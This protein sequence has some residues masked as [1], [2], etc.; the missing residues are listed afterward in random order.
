[1]SNFLVRLKPDRQKSKRSTG[2]FQLYQWGQ[3]T[4]ENPMLKE[5]Y[6]NRTGGGPCTPGVG[7]LF[8]DC[9]IWKTTLYITES[10]SAAIRGNY[11]IMSIEKR[12]AERLSIDP[13][14][15]EREPFVSMSLWSARNAV[16]NG[17]TYIYDKRHFFSFHVFRLTFAVN[18]FSVAFK[19]NIANTSL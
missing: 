9:L 19:Y 11:F 18:I 8:T 2:D 10:N 13:R 3:S 6:R 14:P 12:P 1:M 5:W 17:Q 16:E 4:G 7:I 15:F